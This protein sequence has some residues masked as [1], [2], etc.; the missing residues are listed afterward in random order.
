MQSCCYRKLL[1]YKKLI[2]LCERYFIEIISSFCFEPTYGSS[3]P[4]QDLIDY[5]LKC[6]CTKTDSDKPQLPIV[7]EE[8]L[9]SS[10]IIRSYILKL[11]ISVK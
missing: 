2:H 1:K 3:D 8:E 10:P 4:D 6:V 7:E 11:L 9:N 5:L